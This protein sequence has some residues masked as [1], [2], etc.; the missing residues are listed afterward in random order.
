MEESAA[1]VAEAMD[2]TP[3]APEAASGPVT[4]ATEA[5]DSGATDSGSAVAAVDG[6]FDGDDDDDAIGDISDDDADVV[7]EISDDDDTGATAAA[8]KDVSKELAKVRQDPKNRT[9]EGVFESD[10]EDGPA[11]TGHDA[12][13]VGSASTHH[14]LFTLS[15]RC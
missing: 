15:V 11:P 4:E 13:E 10:D 2:E 7:G 6:L 5:A 14:S 9:T 12:S 1:P 3:V 8:P